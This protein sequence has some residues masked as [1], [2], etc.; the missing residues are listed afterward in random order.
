[1][2]NSSNS[3]QP[4]RFKYQDVIDELEAV[5]KVADSL[6]APNNAHIIPQTIDAL[7]GSRLHDGFYN[8]Q[9]NQPITTRRSEGE[10]HPGSNGPYDLEGR[11]CYSWR[12]KP[13]KQGRKKTPA[14]S[15]VVEGN[16]STRMELFGKQ[17]AHDAVD[18]RLAAWRFEIGDNVSPGVFFHSQVSWHI[19][20]SVHNSDCDIP[21]FPC[22]LMTPGECLDFLL[23]ELFQIEW[24]KL[25]QAHST[26][27]KRWSA[28]QG[29]RM[30]RLLE[31]SRKVIE[32][33]AGVSPWIALKTWKPDDSGFM[34]R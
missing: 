5:A 27:V 4:P 3:Y 32:A 25:Q 28:S 1:M 10:H 13:E 7:E 12:I 31:Q 18:E 33:S 20:A 26:D 17:R 34:L 16:I 21:R 30:S 24:P 19:P 14:Q 22:F 11:L 15:F 23:G 8:W 6:L 29:Y 9:L 2:S